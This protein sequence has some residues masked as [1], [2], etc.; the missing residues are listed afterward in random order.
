MIYLD[1]NVFIYA[2]SNNIDDFKQKEKALHYLK[3][4][5]QEDILITS[6]VVL[7]EFAFVS[8]K[9]LEESKNINENLAFISDFIQTPSSKLFGNILEFMNTYGFHKHSFDVYH[10]CYSQDLQCNTLIT[11]D[12][13]FNKFKKYIDFEIE[14]L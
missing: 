8:K 14:V 13:G 3:K 1:T 11:F 2:L 7:Y 4:A 10:L 12:K 6:E 9:L 5:I